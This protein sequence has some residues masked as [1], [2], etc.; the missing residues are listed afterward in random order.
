MGKGEEGREGEGKRGEWDWMGEECVWGEETEDR[1]ANREE[2]IS[3]KHLQS[4]TQPPTQ[5]LTFPQPRP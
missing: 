4:K 2:R 1:R 5:A 3:A